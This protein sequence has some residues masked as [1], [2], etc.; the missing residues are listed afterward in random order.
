MAIITS[1]ALSIISFI[2][3]IMAIFISEQFERNDPI[4]WV[5][6]ALM[7]NSLLIYLIVR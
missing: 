1:I 5:C 2:N 3:I 7:I 6:I 4:L